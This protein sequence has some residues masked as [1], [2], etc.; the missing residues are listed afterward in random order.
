MYRKILILVEN[1]QQLYPT[2]LK[3]LQG[4]M[5]LINNQQIMIRTI[6]K[7]LIYQQSMNPN[8]NMKKMNKINQK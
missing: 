7:N 6:L 1:N 4:E 2:I 8:L 5:V 3:D